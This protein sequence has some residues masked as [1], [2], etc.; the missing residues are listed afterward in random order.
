MDIRDRPF[1]YTNQ[2]E[3]TDN[4]RLVTR[5]YP[6]DRFNS[7]ANMSNE[8]SAGGDSC[9]ELCFSPKETGRRIWKVKVFGVCTDRGPLLDNWTNSLKKNGYDHTVIGM[10]KK[11]GGWSWRTKQYI[12]AL[13]RESEEKL[14]VLTDANDLFFI[15]P[16]NELVYN[17]RTYNSD[18]VIGGEHNAFTGAY[19]KNLSLKADVIEFAK[20][21]N[22]S[23]RY[24]VPNGGFVMGFRTPLLNL[25]CGNV[26]EEDDQEGYLHNWL[27]HPE[28]IK[29][30]IYARLIANIVYDLPFLSGR[31][32]ERI[33]MDFFEFVS[34]PSSNYGEPNRLRVR[35][36][37]TQACPCAMHFPGK[38]A[39]AYNYYGKTLY[40]NY[41][42]EMVHPEFSMQASMKKPWSASLKSKFNRVT[43]AFYDTE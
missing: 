10:G 18:V 21:R 25:L 32:D 19:R 42:N 24:L 1:D 20:S 39:E 43:S 17:F 33:E 11:W 16:P 27:E 13:S 8:V 6:I 30:D 29:I 37:E 35:S 5:E 12:E 36:T 41:F 3:T 2:N 28:S 7:S 9:V 38:N 31:D 23:T 22:T 4:T 40:P 26:K 15:A 14:F 34:V